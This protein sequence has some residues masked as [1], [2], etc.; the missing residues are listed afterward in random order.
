MNDAAVAGAARRPGRL[1]GV[2]ALLGTQCLGAFNANLYKTTVSLMAVELALLHDGG[3]AL[4]SLSSVVFV[5]PYLLFSGYAGH[6]ADR[7][8]KRRVVI[9]AKIAEFAVMA[10]ALVALMV[11][12]IELLILVLF[13]VSTQATFFSPA[14]YGMLPEALPPSALSWANGIMEMTRYAAVILGTAVA[15]L[16]LWLWRGQPARIGAVLVGVAAAGLLASLMIGRLPRVERA[17]DFRWNPWGEI[18]D[19]LR[20]LAAARRLATAVA[21]IAC[22]EFLCALVMLDIIVLAKTRMGLDDLEIGV[23]GTIVGIGAG[24][25]SLLA[26]RLSGDRIEPGLA[27]AGFVGIGAVLL[28]LPVAAAAYAPTAAAFLLLGGFAGLVI[29]PLNALVQHE[30]GAGEKGRLIATSNLLGMAG[31]VAASVCLWLLHDLCGVPADR[32]LAL[33]GLLALALALC[34][35]RQPGCSARALVRLA[36]SLRRAPRI[37]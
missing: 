34:A 12:R 23:F 9:L 8:D 35:A 22:F 1:R 5:A 33:A 11:G 29:V 15:G 24:G 25:G 27:V 32:I 14:K 37:D 4:L 28:A 36:A 13:L 3:A 26:G 16:L 6:V 7:F 18:A 20:R 30:S 2:R 17:S 19:G 10:V 31:V 21:G